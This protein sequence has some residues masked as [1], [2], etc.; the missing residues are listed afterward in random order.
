MS[1]RTICRV[2]WQPG[3]EVVLRRH[4]E[5]REDEARRDRAAAERVA[6]SSRHRRLPD[7]GRHHVLGPLSVRHVATER[8]DGV[9]AVLLI[10]EVEVEGVSVVVVPG[11]VARD[12]VPCAEGARG[13][14]EVDGR[15]RGARAP[16]GAGDGEGRSPRL[17][18]EAS[19]GVRA[20]GE[21]LHDGFGVGVHGGSRVDGAR[22][23]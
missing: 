4:L 21:L 19:F 8:D 22:S 5:V 13:E 11:L 17:A 3:E 2:L 12:A 14:Q 7:P 16:S 23:P 15:A 18:V 6:L 1:L 20:E 10:D 9:R